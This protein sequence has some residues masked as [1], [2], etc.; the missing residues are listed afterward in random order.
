MNSIEIEEY[1]SPIALNAKIAH[2]SNLKY[3]PLMI[4][5]T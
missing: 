3:T 1:R 4:D 2:R 5:S